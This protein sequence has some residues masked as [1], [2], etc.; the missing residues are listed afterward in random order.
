[1]T[2]TCAESIA[3]AAQWGIERVVLPRELSIDEIRQIAERVT[4]PLEVFVHG[5]LCVAYSGQCLTS[6]SL[7]G[8]SAN[9][10]Q[11]A[12]A[13]RLPY[14]LYC[15]GEHVALEQARYLLSPQDLAAY[16]LLPDLVGAGV[17]SLKIEGRLKSPEY[18]ASIT[19]HYRTALDAAFEG[20]KCTLDDDVREEMELTFSRGFAPGW[21]E[22]CDHKRLVPADSSAKRGVRVGTVTCI[23]DG[24]IE[25]RLERRLRVGDGVMFDCGFDQNEQPGGRV[26]QLW[27]A[28]KLQKLAV[29]RGTVQITL[30]GDR[31][32]IATLAPGVIVWKSDDPA[33]RQ[34]LRRTFEVA[35]PH[36][37][38]PLHA[39]LSASVDQ[40]L[41]LRVGLSGRPQLELVSEQT[42]QQAQRHALT[43]D[44]AREQL[45]R[46][47]HTPFHLVTLDCHIE[48]EPM[49]PLS[50]F[51]QLRRRMIEE[52]SQQLRQVPTRTIADHSV[53]DRLRPMV[54]SKLREMSEHE[55]DCGPS[56]LHLLCRTLP[57]IKMAVEL[58]VN[59]LTADFAD[60]REYR[61][62]AQLAS[63]AGAEIWLATPRIQKP[64]ELG[65][66]LAMEKHPAA[67]IM[68]R[69]LAAIDFF[70]GRGRRV[71]ADYSLNVANELTAKVIHDL[72]V[73][74]LT[75]SYDLNRDQLT[76][77]VAATPPS[78]LEI[79]I[80]QHMPMFHMEHC[81]FC[82][83]LSPGTNK[84]NC[85]RPCDRHVVHL[86]D[87]VGQ[88]HLLTADVGC[89]NTLFNAQAQSG[90]ELVAQLQ[91]RGVRWFRVE[92]LEEA[93]L[94][95]ITRVVRLYRQ[96]LAG[97]VTG[98][99]VWQ[100]LHAAN[101]VGVT[102]GTLE[103]PRDPLAIL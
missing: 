19:R 89:R 1:M 78:W 27:Q 73:E 23:D 52:L 53:M 46:L 30:Q 48:G 34:R 32:D 100:E 87:R 10:G 85:G 49:V 70:I 45:G 29:E 2:L 8:R 58:G 79:V 80:H 68:A 47:G 15:D 102:R 88:R 17:C 59:C 82:A 4:M 11:C 33:I 16:D 38:L 25:L 43:G 76:Q 65:V 36:Q 98:K 57:Q 90:A 18:V 54:A 12:Q 74:R 7:G 93:T 3:V 96:L 9:R 64:G 6:E 35:D 77:L 50:V 97:Q 66:F 31:V 51:G 75:P 20:R 21:L 42:L 72:G 41:R 86:E 60:V 69:N 103:A 26:R 67:G 91:G 99:H 81:V 24:R 56:R 94:H 55:H 92:L 13:C 83:M 28:G 71:L 61:E 37:K 62:A 14:E 5:A 39:E 22:G 95:E 44:V 63:Q 84:T 101:R 40:P